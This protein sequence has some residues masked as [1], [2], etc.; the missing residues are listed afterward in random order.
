MLIDCDS[1]VMQHTDACGDCIVT[2]LL[3]DLGVGA[4]VRRR[5]TVNDH[6]IEALGNLANVGLV[7]PLKL[8]PKDPIADLPTE[9]GLNDGTTYTIASENNRET[10]ESQSTDTGGTRAS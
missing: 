2:V 6:E 8:V 1:C 7:P 5:L 3:A 9:D 10:K 4:N